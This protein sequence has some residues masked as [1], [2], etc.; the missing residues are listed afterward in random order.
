MACLIAMS[1]PNAG[2]AWDGVA[3]SELERRAVELR[4]RKTA[5]RLGELLL[6]QTIPEVQ[7]AET[8]FQQALA[9]AR[10]RQAQSWELRA[11]MSLCRL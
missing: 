2:I 7:A 9:V 1:H 10:Q 4:Q 8:C 3:I 5:E 6:R 11:A